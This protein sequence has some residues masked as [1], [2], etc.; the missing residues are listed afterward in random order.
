MSEQMASSARQDSLKRQESA[1]GGIKRVVRRQI[2]LPRVIRAIRTIKSR[3]RE[4]GPALRT[5]EGVE[6]RFRRLKCSIESIRVQHGRDRL[7]ITVSRIRTALTRNFELK[8]KSRYELL[9]NALQGGGLPLASLSI[10]GCGTHEIRYTQLLRYFLDPKEPHGL[11]AGVLMAVIA[12]EL[13]EAGRTSKDI[14]W[15]RAS[16]EAE[17]SLGNARAGGRELGCTVDLFL[18][19]GS[20]V[21][22]IE[23]KIGSPEAGVVNAGEV[24]QLRRYSTAFTN[25]FPELSGKYI[26]KIFLTPEGRSPKEDLG[27]VPLSY[28]EVI[29]RTAK[30]LSDTSLSRIARHNL[31]CFLWDLL[32]GP[33]SLDETVREHLSVLITNAVEDTQKHLRLKRWCRECLPSIGD[34]L[35]IVEACY[36]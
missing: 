29:S 8:T 21:V 27:W 11:K 28:H 9:L 33:L 34:L 31:C 19:L 15:K 12:P 25:N 26:L 32:S 24:S 6:E 13:R 3:A 4:T 14:D 10:C 22:M 18:R 2:Y 1:I 35:T 20:F 30:L 5:D 36:G 16:I 23:N 17:F 7:P